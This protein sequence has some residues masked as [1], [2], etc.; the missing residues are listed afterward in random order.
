M[1]IIG[2]IPA[3]AGSKRIP[4]KAL[5]PLAGHPLIAYAIRSAEASGI[6]SAIYV[7]SDDEAILDRAAGYVQDL[8]TATYHR[9]PSK[10]NE[11]DIF[12]IEWF[13]KWFTEAGG[14]LPD[15]FAILR[16]TSPFRTPMMIQTAWREFR[17]AKWADSLRAVERWEGPHPGKM[18][19][20]VEE[21][22]AHKRLQ[23][24]MTG[25]LV[26]RGISAPFH[27][28][29]T[30]QLPAVY[31]QTAALEIARTE[32]CLR[33]QSIAGTAIMPF[34]TTGYEGL[35]LNTEDDWRLAEA[36]VTAGKMRLPELKTA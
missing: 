5:R 15:A 14:D 4:G 28:S 23:P 3:R 25:D 26:F 8:R 21:S 12:W 22:G 13:W 9:Y 35:D 27:S 1:T 18:W 2:L 17:S 6:F 10:D 7:C 30:Q 33:T 24:A 11:P 29:P 34:V 16:P 36:L 20:I 19:K 32:M 31:R